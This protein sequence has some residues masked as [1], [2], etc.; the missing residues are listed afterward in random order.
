VLTFA[1]GDEI[2]ITCP[3]PES[4]AAELAHMAAFYG[5]PPPFAFAIDQDGTVTAYT[6][7]RG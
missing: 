3:T 1:E 5:P 7:G 4:F 2:R 6:Q